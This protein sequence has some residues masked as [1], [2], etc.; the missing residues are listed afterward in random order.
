MWGLVSLSNSVDRNLLNY[1][2]II[3]LDMN[4]K[5]ITVK[6]HIFYVF[7]TQVKFRS[8]KMLFIIPLINLFFIHNFRS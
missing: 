7:N 6:L 2:F 1:S 3:L 5:N 4:F 8:N